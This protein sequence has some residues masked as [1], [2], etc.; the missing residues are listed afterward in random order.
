MALKGEGDPR[1]VVREREDGRNVNGWH[2]TD[3]DVSTWAHSRIK[4]LLAPEL[5]TVAANPG[6]HF[7]AQLDSVDT[8][9]GDA[10]LYNRKGVLKVLYDLKVSGKWSSCHESKDDRTHGE[11]KFE[12]F[13]EDPEVVVT[14]DTKSKGEILYKTLIAK[15]LQPV[16]RAK[17]RIFIEELHAG[18]DTPVDG[19]L[20]S[21]SKPKPRETKVTDYLRSGMDQKPKQEVKKDAGDVCTLNLKDQ[22]VCSTMDL[23][24]ALT[25]RPRLEAITRAKAVSNAVPDGELNLMNGT[26][27]GKYKSVAPG[28]AI[29]LSW[30]LKT[31]DAATKP[32]H[33][34]I[35][36][37]EEE[38][39]TRLAVVLKGVPKK[40]RTET[41]GFWR[42]QIFQSIKVV[43]GYRSA[44]GLF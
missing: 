31:W 39:Y 22:F 44:S 28:S 2:W 29:S 1:W 20:L 15:A 37:S 5:I 17:S 23:F 12:L 33:A 9:E 7:G 21:K 14:V 42:T 26:V 10:T 43:M 24:Q 8:V 40:Y 6:T 38:N 27:V 19:L 32:A 36:I 34:D 18:A 13:D 16:V 41:E 25:D 11:F 4:E 35:T 30:K 3:K